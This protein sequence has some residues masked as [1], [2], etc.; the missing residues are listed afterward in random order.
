MIGQH[1][2]LSTIKNQVNNKTYP[3]FALFCGERGSEQME[4]CS[5]LSKLLHADMFLFS[6]S[7]EDIREL[8]DTVYSNLADIR[9]YVIVN[10][11]AMSNNA[12][13]ALLKIAEETPK[14]AYIVMLLDDINNTLDTIKSRAIV[15]TMESYSSKQ[16]LC[17]CNQKKYT[18]PNEILSICSTPGELDIVTKYNM[19]EFTQFTRKVFENIHHVQG[20]N[21]FKIEQKLNLSD[22]STKY[23]LRLFWKLYIYLCYTY[24]DQTQY[25]EAIKITSY[26]LRQLRING[27]NKSMLTDMWILAI[28]ECLLYNDLA[29]AT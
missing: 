24:I 3:H 2:L 1:Q 8:I 28:R 27:I 23:D 25:A 21:A 18:V 14:N 11:D 5:E 22:D 17:Y 12:K 29:Y 15:Y 4:L 9:L 20:A 10:A 26:H 6:S 19:T 16:L 7:I 13:N